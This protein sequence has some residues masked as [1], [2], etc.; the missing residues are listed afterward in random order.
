MP[1]VDNKTFFL[2]WLFNPFFSAIYLLKNFKDTK[3]VGP[4]LLLSVFFGISFIVSTTGGDSKTYADELKHYHQHNL[5][6]SE[7]QTNLYSEEGT[8]LDVYQP[9]ITWIVSLISDNTKVLFVIF[10][11][12]FG[13]FYFKSLILIR[14]Y[15]GIPL[16]GLVL[17]VFLLLAFTNPIWNING[18]RMWTAVMMFFYGVL[19][20]TLNNDK[21]G[22]WFL[23]LPIF[24]H[25]SILIALVLFLIHNLIPVNR[26]KIMFG[27]FIATFFLGELNLEVIGDYFSQLP[28]FTQS[29]SG[30][31][32]LEYAEGLK[33]AELN[34][35]F[36]Q[37]LIEQLGKYSILLM[38]VLMVFN[39]GFK[40]NVVDKKFDIFLTMGLLFASFSNIASSLP[41]GGRFLVVSNLILYT[42]FLLYLNQKSEIPFF[43]KKILILSLIVIIAFNIRM[44][45]NYIGVFFFIGNPIINWFIEDSPILDFIKSLI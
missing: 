17:T 25:F 34:M 32:N 40:K 19:V 38:A 31:L 44:G 33:D 39:F 45:L 26:K 12:V 29:R 28:G 27:I 24:I 8:K 18:V 23:V 2:L 7:L 42:A 22:W 6:F 13:Y 21:K 41:S 37:V 5:T 11:I 43:L 35:S 15:L 14:T 20:V 10:S 9:V 3:K 36:E 30:Y 1:K 4:Y 16:T